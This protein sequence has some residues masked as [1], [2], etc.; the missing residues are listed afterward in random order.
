VAILDEKAAFERELPTLMQEHAGEF[1]VFFRGSCHGIFASFEAA[2]QAA[3]EQ[4]GSTAEFLVSRIEIPGAPEAVS[5]ALYAGV[6]F[7]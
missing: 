2:Y 5:M 7:G 3:L 4:F 1:V 6:M